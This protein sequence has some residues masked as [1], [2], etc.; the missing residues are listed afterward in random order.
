MST[1]A[2]FVVVFDSQKCL[3]LT[4]GSSPNIV[5]RGARDQILGLYKLTTHVSDVKLNLAENLDE[6]FLWHKRFGH[7]NFQSLFH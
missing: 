6:V 4:K 5:V 3:L 7:L 2:R 1:D